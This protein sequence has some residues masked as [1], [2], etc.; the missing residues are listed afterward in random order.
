M[1]KQIYLT[2]FLLTLHI[3]CFSQSKESGVTELF[4]AVKS[5]VTAKDKEVFLIE[6]RQLN[7]SDDRNNFLLDASTQ[8]VSTAF[9]DERAIDQALFW[10]EKIKDSQLKSDA[11]IYITKVLIEEKKYK[12]AHSIL[13]NQ[14]SGLQKDETGYFNPTKDQLQAALVYGELLYNEGDYGK[15]AQYLKASLNVPKYVD[16]YKELFIQALING[17]LPGLNKE[18]IEKVL[19]GEG[20]VSIQFK[21]DVKSWFINTDGNALQYDAL[22]KKASDKRRSILSEKVAKMATEYPAPNFILKDP[23]GKLVSLASLKG[24]TLVLD[25]WATWCQPCVASFPGMK[26]AV[27]Y[28]KN[29]STV[30][31]LFI[32]TAEKKG[33][34]VK[35][36]ALALINEKKYPFHV[37]LDTRDPVTG[38]C[39]VAESFKVGSIPAKFVINKEGIV[40]FSTTGFVSEDDAIDEIKLMI[41][42]ANSL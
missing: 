29:D 25:F 23:D 5:A 19:M 9:A 37:Y 14:I 20:K 22:E 1:K 2:I 30:V 35:E 32:H 17:K 24:K 31:F 34:K 11:N 27:E 3:I 7:T 18:L 4:N 12:E 36:Q 39:P 38:K 10:C 28:Y 40:K 26:K 42:Q 21:N 16:M 33:A 15:A 13:D 6:M 8:M 41:D